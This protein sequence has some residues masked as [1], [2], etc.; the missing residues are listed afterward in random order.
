M[1]TL[2]LN[3]PFL[4][5]AVPAFISYITSLTLK[6]ALPSNAFCLKLILKPCIRST[7]INYIL[8]PQ[9]KCY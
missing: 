4:P 1:T 8:S 6:E 2:H 7:F 3:D 9:L 5:T